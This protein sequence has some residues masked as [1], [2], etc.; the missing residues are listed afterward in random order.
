MSI[1]NPKFHRKSIRLPEYD[2]SQEGAYFI[3][4]CTHGRSCLFGKI[5]N[6][7]MELNGHGEIADKSWR[8]IPQHFTNVLLGEYIIM[9][10]HIHGT[11]IIIEPPSETRHAV[12]LP[13]G[14]S[15]G[16]PQAGSLSTIV[17][18]YKSAVTRQINVVRAKN[19][20][21]IWQSRFYEHVIRNDKSYNKIRR[22][23]VDNPLCWPQDD[24]NP[25]R[26]MIREIKR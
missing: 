25:N 10:N 20:P 1:N 24:E 14:A 6:S 5:V 12:S 21:A 15:F 8:E 19:E 18:S 22:Y 17:R 13:S 26:L 23:I 11:I 16:K 7:R 3:T 2:Y 9:P 4:I